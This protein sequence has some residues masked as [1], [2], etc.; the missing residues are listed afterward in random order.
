[1][2]LPLTELQG[3]AISTQ[4]LSQHLSTSPIDADEVTLECNACVSS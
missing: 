1:M 3:S 4:W 2:I